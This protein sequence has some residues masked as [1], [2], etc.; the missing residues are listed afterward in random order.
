MTT[1]LPLADVR[2]RLSPIVN[3]VETTHERVVITKNGRPSAVL[4]SYEDLE[5]LEET[6][7]ILSDRGVAQA[8]RESLSDQERFS[9]DD[10]R[11]DLEAR[12]G[13]ESAEA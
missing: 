9:V 10:I 2:D 4:I 11:R 13:S 5:S 8:I 12:S 1:T 6:V 7:E 3:S